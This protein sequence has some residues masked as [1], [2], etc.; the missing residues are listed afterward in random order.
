MVASAIVPRNTEDPT[1]QDKRERGAINVFEKK[2]RQISR[3]IRNILDEQEYEV[4]VLNSFEHNARSYKFKLDGGILETINDK[5]KKLI[6]TVLL[7]GGRRG[8]WFLKSY[9]EPAYVQGT[10]AQ[11][12]NLSIQ[13]EFY[14]ATQGSLEKVLLSRPYAARFGLVQARVFEEMRGFSDVMRADLGSTLARGMA[15]GQNPLIIAKDIEARVGVSAARARTIAR[16]EI[17]MAHRMAK[18]QESED[19]R[20]RLGIRTL[21]MHISALSPTTREWHAA[22]HATLHTVQDQINWWNEDANGI[23]CKCSTTAV[24]VDEND[25]PYSMTAIDRARKNK[26]SY[27][28]KQRQLDK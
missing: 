3:G 10:A 7:E 26:E 8:L 1:G 2:M 23:N 18:M 21:E 17:G 22:R 6:D 25:K 14:A 28:E 16:T 27:E 20:L 15:A 19:A 5:I 24:L 13:S 11:V 4:I 9:V 12:A